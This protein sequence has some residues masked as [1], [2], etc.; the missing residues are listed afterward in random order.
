M[1]QENH[2][3]TGKPSRREMLRWAPAGAGAALLPADAAAQGGASRS[4]KPNIVLI[5]SDQFRAD[6][7]G[8]MGSN[9][10]NLTPS[11]DALAGGGVLFRSA[12]CNQPVCAPARACIFTGQYPEKHGVWKNGPG[13]QTNAVTLATALRQEGYSANYIGKWHLAPNQGDQAK[14]TWGPVAPVHRGGFLDHWEGSNLMEFTSHGFEG[15]LYD[16]DGKPIRFDGTYRTDFMTDRAV[17]FLQKPGSKPFLLVLSYLETHH[18]N[19]IYRFVPPR[20]YEDKFRDFFVPQDLRPLPGSWPHQLA[21]YYG[22]VAGIDDAVGTVLGA[23][24]QQGLED[25]TRP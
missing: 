1:A 5:I 7:L 25:R 20:K 18:Q 10:M 15:E 19:D 11:L 22:C 8:C 23:L 6:N 2:D 13:L 9:P 17:R 4:G 21:D 12:I 24:K 16:N 3:S 14:S